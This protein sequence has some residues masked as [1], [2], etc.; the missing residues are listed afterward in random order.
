MFSGNVNNQNNN[1]TQVSFSK[2][3]FIPTEVGLEDIDSQTLSLFS[4]EEIEHI[5]KTYTK[6]GV[7]RK[8]DTKLKYNIVNDGEDLY[9]IYSGYQQHKILN[10]KLGKALGYNEYTDAVVKHALKLHAN[11]ATNSHAWL[12]DKVQN[13]V[14]GFQEKKGR[15]E[16]FILKKKGGVV[17]NSKDEPVTFR[18]ESKSIHRKTRTHLLQHHIKELDVFD[19]VDKNIKMTPVLWLEVARKMIAAID[20]LHTKFQILHGDIKLENVRYDRAT[21]KIELIDFDSS[22]I[23][24]S[25]V[26]FCD[27]RFGTVG[28]CSPEVEF[29]QSDYLYNSAIDMYSAGV[30]I[31]LM[32]QAGD[33]YEQGL[34]CSFQIDEKIKEDHL[35]FKPSQQEVINKFFELIAGLT[36]KNPE[37]RFDAKKAM[38]LIVEIEQKLDVDQRTV[39]IGLLNVKEYLALTTSHEKLTFAR[40]LSNLD[41]IYLADSSKNEDPLFYIKIKRELEAFSLTVMPDLVHGGSME[42]ML[43]LVA[44]T[45]KEDPGMP[46][47]LHAYS[48]VESGLDME[49]VIICHADDVEFEEEEE[50]I[51]THSPTHLTNSAN[52]SNTSSYDFLQSRSHLFAPTSTNSSGGS[53]KSAQNSYSDSSEEPDYQ[54]LG[55]STRV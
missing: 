19:L 15:K 1:S 3:H 24:T 44:E 42:E 50:E 31:G 20:E 21:G 45:E 8:K 49:D 46:H 25:G 37:T 52:H 14:N 12:I 43:N 51:L 41:R 6:S 55:P 4:A 38:Q 30:S 35:L 16:L 48:I 33:L 39:K 26:A 9:A 17:L 28:Y 18:K 47:I 23:M 54:P 13:V 32:L 11:L 27:F 36:D 2:I 40:K 7:Y 29:N 5:K 22:L 53:Y 34:T 10:N